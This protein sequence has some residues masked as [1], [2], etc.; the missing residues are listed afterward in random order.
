[1]LSITITVARTPTKFLSKKEKDVLKDYADDLKGVAVGLGLAGGVMGVLAA[2]P[3]PVVTK[4]TV[5]LWGVAVGA[6]A[7]GSW[8][9]GRLARDPPDLDYQTIPT[10]PR[11]KVQAL[12]P[13]AKVTR[14]LA[15][16]LT[17]YVSIETRKAALALTVL[18]GIERAAGAETNGELRWARR[19]VRAARHH[20]RTLIDKIR[21]SKRARQRLDAAWRHAGLPNPRLDTPT[22]HGR[23]AFK[24]AVV[25]A[26]R[27]MTRAGFPQG[28]IAAIDRAVATRSSRH[29]RLLS[30]LG[31]DHAE[32]SAIKALVSFAR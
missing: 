17:A 15:R 5:A 14:R 1:V 7:G 24:L 3:E 30:L 23:R 25:R 6:V 19:Q 10:P 2:V 12:H 28:A 16:A 29:V 26:D 4:G 18:Q 20:A 31:R 22:A 32:V 11:L 21:A 27:L 8:I 13:G 9:M